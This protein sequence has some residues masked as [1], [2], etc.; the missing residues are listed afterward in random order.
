MYI[1]ELTKREKKKNHSTLT[2]E[3][4]LMFL[5]K[6]CQE[7]LVTSPLFKINLLTSRSHD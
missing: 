5:F 2:T 4:T 3:C 1:N 6:G 7:N